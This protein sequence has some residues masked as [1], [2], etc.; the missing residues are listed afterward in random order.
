MMGI[1]PEEMGTIGAGAHSGAR[2][3]H[4][5][6][7]IRTKSLDTLGKVPSLQVLLIKLGGLFPLAG[8][9]SR[10]GKLQGRCGAAA[11]LPPSLL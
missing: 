3:T 7:G 4:L 6:Y 1:E 5:K 10:G 2:G 8:G 11:F 9:L